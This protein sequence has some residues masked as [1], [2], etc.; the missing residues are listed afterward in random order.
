MHKANFLSVDEAF[1][2]YS[3]NSLNPVNKGHHPDLLS[4]VEVDFLDFLVLHLFLVFLPS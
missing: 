1:T 3:Q 2:F 4:L